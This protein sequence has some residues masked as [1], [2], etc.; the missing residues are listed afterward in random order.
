[1]N[2]CTKFYN[3]QISKVNNILLD[4]NNLILKEISKIEQ[5]TN[6]MA[7]Q[8][9]FDT[10]KTINLDICS[11]FLKETEKRISQ[12]ERQKI[13]GGDVLLIEDF[14]VDMKQIMDDITR[15]Q[16]SNNHE[17]KVKRTAL[18]RLISLFKPKH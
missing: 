9:V 16:D 2:T 4:I 5:S 7:T 3:T 13:T 10:S 17:V 14:L 12:L 1:V 8:E 6:D 15:S 11:K 18:L